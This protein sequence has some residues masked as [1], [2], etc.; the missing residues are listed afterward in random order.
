MCLY[1]LCSLVCMGAHKDRTSALGSTWSTSSIE[2]V[3]LQPRCA[4]MPCV[5]EVA[6]TH[7]QQLSS[8]RDSGVQSRWPLTCNVGLGVLQHDDLVTTTVRTWLVLSSPR[9]TLSR[10]KL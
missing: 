7:L 3:C 10:I 1:H 5:S 4:M 8:V 6:S 2:G 9:T